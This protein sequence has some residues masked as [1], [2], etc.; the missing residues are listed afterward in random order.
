M[1]WWDGDKGGT[2]G[3]GMNKPRS[4]SFASAESFAATVEFEI[5]EVCTELAAQVLRAGGPLLQIIYAI[6][7][8]SGRV[9]PERMRTSEKKCQEPLL[10]LILSCLAVVT[11]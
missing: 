4:W 2:W 10:C 7:P 5:R 8:V 6:E 11:H 3:E 1:P 9:P